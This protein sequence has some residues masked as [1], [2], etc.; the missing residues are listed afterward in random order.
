MTD[1]KP[2]G[3]A[4][5]RVTYSESIKIRATKVGEYIYARYSKTLILADESG[6]ELPCPQ[7][8][9]AYSFLIPH[10]KPWWQRIGRTFLRQKIGTLWFTNEHRKA[11]HK[12]WVLEIFGRQNVERMLI[13]AENLAR[14]FNVKVHVR[15]QSEHAGLEHDAPS[16]W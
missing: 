16:V 11:T 12:E 10:E 13:L 6:F 9:D 14:D 1:E 8:V 15:L 7:E 2:A 3:E 5:A 4:K